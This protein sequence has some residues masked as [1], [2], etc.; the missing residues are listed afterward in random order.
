MTKDGSCQM[1][2]IVFTDQT[3]GD[4]TLLQLIT[5]IEQK[6]KAQGKWDDYWITWKMPTEE[7]M[8]QADP[9]TQLWTKTK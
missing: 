4:S 6:L 9:L 7:E 1:W 2:Q 8:M 5:R 3:M